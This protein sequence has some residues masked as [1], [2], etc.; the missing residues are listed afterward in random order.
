MWMG[1]EQRDTDKAKGCHT[2]HE[3]GKEQKRLVAQTI[4]EAAHHGSE[5]E[6][7]EIECFE[8]NC[9]DGRRGEVLAQVEAEEHKTDAAGNAQQQRR[10]DG[11]K[12]GATTHQYACSRQR[13][14]S[15]ACQTLLVV[16]A[17]GRW[18]DYL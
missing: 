5:H 7:A 4:G 12:E 6:F 3:R 17:S 11:G 15:L 2:S 13:L 14:C 8:Y 1:K 9:N 18:V 16:N 10:K